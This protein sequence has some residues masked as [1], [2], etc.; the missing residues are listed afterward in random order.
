MD[1]NQSVEVV[2]QVVAMAQKGGLLTL[3][4]A[5]IVSQALQVLETSIVAP[6][7]TPVEEVKAEVVSEKSTK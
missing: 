5:V 1:I 2:K 4:D 7:P 3:Q 6:A